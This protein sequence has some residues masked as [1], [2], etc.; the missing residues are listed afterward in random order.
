MKRLGLKILLMMYSAMIAAIALIIALSAYSFSKEFDSLRKDLEQVA[1]EAVAVIDEDM[2]SEVIKQNTMDSSEYSEIQQALIDFKSSK[3]ITYIYTM[4]HGNNEVAYFAVDGALEDAGELGEEYPLSV[5]MARAF[6][7]EMASSADPN[8]DEWGT[9]IS[10]YA[11][12]ADSEGNII[13]LVGVDK[14][15]GMFVN[16][17]NNLTK[18]I[19]LAACI[20][21]IVTGIGGF[22]FSRAIG[23][24][25]R[26]IRDSL[27][28]M[29]EG[30][31]TG[32]IEI[33]TR[34][35]FNAIAGSVKALKQKLSDS[36]YKVQDS[37]HV[38]AEYS[39]NLSALSQ[40]I[41]ATSKEVSEAIDNVAKNTGHQ[42]EEV[43][44]IRTV[45]NSFSEKLDSVTH[46]IVD[47]SEKVSTIDKMSNTSNQDLEALES[48][49]MDIVN[50]FGR[51]SNTLDGFSKQLS[52]IYEITGVINTIADQTNLIA[53]NASIEAARAGESGRGFT[54]VANEIRNL[55]EQSKLSSQNINALLGNV[56]AENEEIMRMAS[57]MNQQLDSEIHTI[58][59]SMVSFKDIIANIDKVTPEIAQISRNIR[60]IDDEKKGIIRSIEAVA[61][62]S[63][64]ISAAS[65]EISASSA[66]S[67]HSSEEV[68][69]AAQKLIEKSHSMV[70]TVKFFKINMDGR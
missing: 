49:M 36:I 39:E 62:K 1:A 40:Q 52:Q 53:L 10:A 17:R 35:E 26:K 54:V 47:I 56:S 44:N 23:K 48:A 58:S 64:E 22:L 38:V 68:A 27:Y 29:S 16:I 7:G 32:D 50:A 4:I 51:M 70:D 18:S 61:Q 60:L 8:T 33:K 59:K 43:D 13:A 24:N 65:E 42:T 6:N 66:Q 2:L 12:I 30:D 63:E 5:E 11:P 9:F 25:V 14:E 34:D 67:S 41:A 21:L 15:V 3:D 45:I 55:A 19:M 28:R 31:L 46:A 57:E 37:S 20:I 69:Q